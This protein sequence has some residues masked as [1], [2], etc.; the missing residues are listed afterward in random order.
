M[1]ISSRWYESSMR[2]HFDPEGDEIGAEVR[3]RP[4]PRDARDVVDDPDHRLRDDPRLRFGQHRAYGPEEPYPL[5]D[6]VVRDRPQLVARGR[7]EMD[8]LVDD[9]AEEIGVVQGM[10]HVGAED[11]FELLRLGSRTFERP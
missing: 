1:A 8:G 10:R 7:R 3:A 4:H 2:E 5:G 9:D 6:V 11:R